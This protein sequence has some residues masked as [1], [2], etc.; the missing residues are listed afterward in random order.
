MRRAR[1]SVGTCALSKLL[2]RHKLL[3]SDQLSSSQNMLGLLLFCVSVGLM[4]VVVF[5]FGRFRIWLLNPWSDPLIS[6]TCLQ[7]CNLACFGRFI[8][9][10]CVMI[11]TWSSCGWYKN[12]V[13]FHFILWRKG[14]C[15]QLSNTSTIAHRHLWWNTKRLYGLLEFAV[16]DTLN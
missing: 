12:S 9:C 3:V 13:P 5:F 10:F 16:T 14:R 4:F 2:S 11:W 7:C 8:F 6:S 15:G 1:S